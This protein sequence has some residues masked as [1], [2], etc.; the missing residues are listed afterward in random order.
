MPVQ[1]NRSFVVKVGEQTIVLSPEEVQKSVE[2]EITV[3]CSGPRCQARNARTAPFSVTWKE[4]EAAKDPQA[5]PDA[6]FTM[7][8]IAP[9]PTKQE[10]FVFCGKSCAVDFLN[11]VYVPPQPPRI[12]LENAKREHEKKLEELNP[13]LVQKTD[14]LPS[15]EDLDA[16]VKDAIP[17]VTAAIGQ[18]DGYADQEADTH[19]EA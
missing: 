1:V 3:T 2:T 10:E 13:H 17:G 9:D 5:L 14:I 6:F 7:L 18:A 8:K 15:P 12:A 4:E 16:A 11:Y 19:V